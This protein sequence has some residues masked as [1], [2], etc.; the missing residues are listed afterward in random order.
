MNKTV[1]WCSEPSRTVA[2]GSSRFAVPTASLT[3]PARR[4]RQRT[5]GREA[6]RAINQPPALPENDASDPALAPFLALLEA[7]NASRPASTVLRLTPVLAARMEALT[8][9]LGEVDPDAPIEG[10]VAL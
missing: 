3:V 7:D 5:S 8:D 1:P 9:G 2:Y 4:C 10:E 6:S